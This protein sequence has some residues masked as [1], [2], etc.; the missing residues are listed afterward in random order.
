MGFKRLLL[1]VLLVSLYSFSCAP[2]LTLVQLEEKYGS[3]KPLIVKYGATERISGGTSW[4]VYMT[5]EDPDGDMDKVTFELKQPGRG[6]YPSQRKKLDSDQ[7][8][9]F[10]G[11][12][13]L[14]TPSTSVKNVGAYQAI[15]FTLKCKVVDKAGHTSEEITLPFR[16]VTGKIEQPVPPNF[17]ENEVQSLGPILIKIIS[18]ERDQDRSR[19]P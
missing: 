13:F 1:V 10:S 14:R 16:I 3:S 2:R 6:I 19:T 18:E 9:T 17:G 12:F 15:T 7:G 4:R 5:A 8:K 11:Y